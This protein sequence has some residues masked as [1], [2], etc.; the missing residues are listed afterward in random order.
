MIPVNGMER[1][2]SLIKLPTESGMVLHRAGIFHKHF[3]CSVCIKDNTWGSL[4]PCIGLPCEGIIV[5]QM[6]FHKCDQ[7]PN[8]LR[9]EPSPALDAFYPIRCNVYVGS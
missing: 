9:A 7:L 5:S 6:K 1:N 3:I 4:G 2:E 8:H